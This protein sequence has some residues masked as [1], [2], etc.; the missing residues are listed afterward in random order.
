MNIRKPGWPIMWCAS[1]PVNESLNTLATVSTKT[2]LIRGYRLDSDPD[3]A[4]GRETEGSFLKRTIAMR[5]RS[6]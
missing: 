1:P 3:I 6:A 2:G 4:P 5:V